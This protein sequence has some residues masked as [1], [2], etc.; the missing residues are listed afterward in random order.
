MKK[1]QK[2]KKKSESVG[3]IGFQFLRLLVQIINKVFH[4]KYKR[5]LKPVVEKLYR[6]FRYENFAVKSE[7]IQVK[8]GK[9]RYKLVIVETAEGRLKVNIGRHDEKASK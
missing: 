6:A 8:K 1:M 5:F 4:S 2:N 9:A 3:Y 7:I